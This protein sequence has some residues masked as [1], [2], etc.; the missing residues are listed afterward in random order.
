MRPKDVD[1]KMSDCSPLLETSRV[2][3]Q[4]A[5]SFLSPVEVCHSWPIKEKLE[6]S[7]SKSSGI[8]RYS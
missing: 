6:I 8:E 5:F 7:E 2:V 1:E 4:L 3:F